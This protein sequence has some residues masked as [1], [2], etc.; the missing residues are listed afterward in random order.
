MFRF[1]TILL[2]DLPKILL[3]IKTSW[4]KRSQRLQNIK[5]FKSIS[6]FDNNS[7]LKFV[8]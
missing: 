3:I 2:F 8:I 5:L 7:Q 4:Q 1:T 6:Y